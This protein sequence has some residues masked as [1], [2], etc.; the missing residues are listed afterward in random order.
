[1]HI[2]ILC[3]FS[4][5]SRELLALEQEYSKRLHG[6]FQVLSRSVKNDK[7]L[8]VE[9]AKIKGHIVLLDEHGSVMNSR[10]FAGYLDKITVSAQRLTFVI[11]GA[12]GLPVEA[13]DFTTEIVALSEL[14]FPHELAKVLLVEQIYRAQ[15]ILE[16]HP[17]HK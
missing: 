10:E 12:E 3:A 14:T 16:G 17:Y 6:R 5:R 9:L 8:L 4:T 15:T 13:R 2:T 7:E 1:M 11:G